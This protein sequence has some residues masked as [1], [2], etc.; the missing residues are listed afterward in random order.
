MEVYAKSCDFYIRPIVIAT[1]D[2]EKM[3]RQSQ[4]WRKTIIPN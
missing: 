1:S 3:L 2:A 4:A